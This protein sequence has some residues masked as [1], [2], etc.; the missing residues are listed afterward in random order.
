MARFRVGIKR[1]AAEEIEAVGTRGF[2]RRIVDGL[3]ALGADPS[4]PG[5]RRLSGSGKFRLVL[6]AYYAL[7]QVDENEGIVRVF[8]FADAD[9]G[10]R[11]HA[12][13]TV[14][15][16]PYADKNVGTEETRS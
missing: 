5:S 8:R 16:D 3:A 1:S 14:G 10:H 9:V 13:N 11:P 2:R 15:G 4:P 7:Y 12:D 6:G